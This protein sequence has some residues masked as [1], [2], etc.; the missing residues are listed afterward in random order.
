MPRPKQLGKKGIAGTP[1]Q[2]YVLAKILK[3]KSLIKEY[4]YN[5]KPCPR[6]HTLRRLNEHW[7]AN[8]AHDILGGEMGVRKLGWIKGEYSSLYLKW[9]D[10]INAPDWSSCWHRKARPK[11]VTHLIPSYRKPT[12]KDPDRFSPGKVAYHWYWGDTGSLKVDHLCG[13][14]MCVNPVHIYSCFNYQDQ[15][16]KPADFLNMPFP[17]RMPHSDLQK[18]VDKESNIAPMHEYTRTLVDPS[19]VKVNFYSGYPCM[20]GH[21]IRHKE[22]HWCL[23]C[24]SRITSNQI[25]F[26]IDYVILAYRWAIN[27]CLPN[28]A[29]TDLTKM[30]PSACWEYH[31]DRLCNTFRFPTYD[32][33]DKDHTCVSFPKLI[34]TLFWGDIGKVKVVRT[35][36]NKNC[37]NPRHF[38]SVFHC[39]EDPMPELNYANFDLDPRRFA[40]L[41][42][43]K[44]K[45]TSSGLKFELPWETSS[46]PPASG[47]IP[48]PRTTASAAQTINAMAS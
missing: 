36:K 12:A 45:C 48:S 7:C 1:P 10:N 41:R 23:E 46:P 22:D 37:F 4:F 21:T 32:S 33:A 5:G 30:D 15:L 17:I 29:K 6:G 42:N 44:N 18:G 34:Y 35:C 27:S 19:Y 25:G 20:W 2:I 11:S 47:V 40:K 3:D 31:T 26:D 13:D 28:M 16:V 43:K 14:P 24:V 8:C 9:L 38:A 39:P